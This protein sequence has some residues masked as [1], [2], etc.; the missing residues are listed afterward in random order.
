MRLS[1][2]DA[3][4]MDA[5]SSDVTADSVGFICRYAPSNV[6]TNF[7]YVL[8][9][10]IVAL[11]LDSCYEATALADWKFPMEFKRARTADWRARVAIGGGF[12]DKR[13]CAAP[14]LR[15]KKCPLA[16]IGVGGCHLLQQASRIASRL[17]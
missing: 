3:H 1:A 15:A 10:I 11:I 5:K 16:V 17:G 8:R 4:Q 7:Q 9:L 12:L 6:A 13:R 14:P 2:A